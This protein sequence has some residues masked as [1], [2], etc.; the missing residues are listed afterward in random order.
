MGRPRER[1][2]NGTV[3][4]ALSFSDRARALGVSPGGEFCV[5]NTLNDI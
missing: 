1:A 4:D 5:R 3:V 2:L